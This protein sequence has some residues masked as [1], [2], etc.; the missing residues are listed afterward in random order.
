MN[1]ETRLRIV[2]TAL[3]A[4][5]FEERITKLALTGELPTTLHLGAG[6]EVCQAAALAALRD[7]DP[8][9]YGHR[10]T[11]YWI[12][13]GVP[14]AAILCDLGHREGGTNRGKGG[15]M[16]VVDPA[17]GVLGQSGTLGA[18]FVIGAGVA[19]A[20]EYL[21]RDTVTI[22]FFGDGTSNRGQFHEAANFAAL[23][24]LPV[25]FFCENNGVGLSV[26]ASAS[27]SVADIADRARG[28][29]MPG[30]I[31]DGSDAGAVYAAT[32]AAA[33]RARAGGGPTLVEAKVV[34]IGGHW[35][36]DSESY[37]TAD[38][39]TALRNQDPLPSLL[40][41]VAAETISAFEADIAADIDNAVAFFRAQP[42]IAAETA[43]ESLYA[44]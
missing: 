25:V 43:L 19:L 11:A 7:D 18:T 28:Y 34:R 36:G 8:M 4:R 13:R 6:Q 16:H 23:R 17:R 26:A 32:A 35:L 14:L 37:R 21:G 9:L 12:A 10:G 3:T 2:R 38:E 31:V 15:V 24:R 41:S 42:P 27:T 33:E 39:R 22:V 29:G 44:G 20:D 40:A 30:V 5:R 1:S